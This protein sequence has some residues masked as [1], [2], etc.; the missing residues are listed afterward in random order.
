MGLKNLEAFHQ[1]RC[2]KETRL[3]GKGAEAE[4]QQKQSAQTETEHPQCVGV[5]CWSCLVPKK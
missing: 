1:D 2:K 5:V 3:A 4:E